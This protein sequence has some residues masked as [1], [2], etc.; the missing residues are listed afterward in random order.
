MIASLLARIGLSHAPAA[1]ADGLRRIHRAFLERVPYEDL[2]VQLGESGPLDEAALIEHVLRDGRGGYCFELNTVL[3]AL[4]RGAGF[5]VGHHQ[6]VVGGEG[7]TNHMAL[8][9]EVDGAPWLADAG[10]G[11]GFLEPLPLREGAYTIGPFTYTLTREP[12]GSWWMGQHE[13]GSVSGFR[14]AAEDSPVAA[15]EPH[16][17]RLSTS[18]DS[19]FV[20]TFVVQQPRADRIVTLRSRTLSEIG[21]G[22]DAKRVL[23]DRDELAAVLRDE[24]GIALGGERLERVWARAAA[25][26]EAFTSAVG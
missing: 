26:H 14:M 16:H 4:L 12:G 7:P 20:K 13:W 24:F 1:D 5:V 19:S 9:V 21:P 25:Q 6:A 2:A 10:L 11:E 18:P 8:V 15:F 17:R 23:A 3:A 22:V